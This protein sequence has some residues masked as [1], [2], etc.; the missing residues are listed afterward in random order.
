MNLLNNRCLFSFYPR[1]KII[2]H[3]DLQITVKDKVYTNKIN[4]IHKLQFLKYYPIKSLYLSVI[5]QIDK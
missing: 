4:K 2:N 3:R 5:Y 1:K